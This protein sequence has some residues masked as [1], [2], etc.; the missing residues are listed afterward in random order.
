[1]VTYSHGSLCVTMRYFIGSAL[2]G[3]IKAFNPGTIRFMTQQTRI[4]NSIARQG[5]RALFPK[6]YTHNAKTHLSQG[7][8]LATLLHGDIEQA[9]FVKSTHSVFLVPK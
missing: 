1:M 9:P 4:V 8:A 7:K 2:V 6:D 5:A 3:K